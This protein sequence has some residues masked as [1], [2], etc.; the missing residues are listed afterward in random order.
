LYVALEYGLALSRV[1][2][3]FQQYSTSALNC[4]GLGVSAVLFAQ[5]VALSVLGD[6][7][8]NTKLLVLFTSVN[9]TLPD[10]APDVPLTLTRSIAVV[11]CNVL[12]PFGVADVFI[13]GGIVCGVKHSVVGLE[14][15]LYTAD[16]YLSRLVEVYAMFQQY[17]TP[18]L[19]AELGPSEP[20]FAIPPSS[21]IVTGPANGILLVLFTSLNSTVPF[22]IPLE[23]V[24]VARSD[25]GDIGKFGVSFGVAD[26][27]IVGGDAGIIAKCRL[28][29]LELVKEVVSEIHNL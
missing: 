7:V 20:L 1:Y 6:D 10:A 14:V 12:S 19:S 23:P 18:A 11:N 24:S 28:S 27:T 3:T 15:P 4:G 5:P 26:V 22:T 13:V 29:V 2:A 8:A 21:G 17:W 25:T 9:I 16:E